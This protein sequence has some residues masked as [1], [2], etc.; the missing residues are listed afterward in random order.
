M[1]TENAASRAG[2][3][4]GKFFAIKAVAGAAQQGADLDE[5][6]RIGGRVKLVTKTI[7]MGMTLISCTPP[8]KGSPLFEF[9]DAAAATGAQPAAQ[10]I[11]REPGRAEPK[12]VRLGEPR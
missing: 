1:A 12:G 7:G 10:N 11:G 5:I 8:G 2:G 9:G 3:V 4:A 6:L